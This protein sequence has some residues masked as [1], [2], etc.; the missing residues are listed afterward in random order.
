MFSALI[1]PSLA[2]VDCCSKTVQEMTLNVFSRRCSCSCLLSRWAASPPKLC[3]VDQMLDPPPLLPP[4]FPPPHAQSRW[5]IQWM[6]PWWQNRFWCSLSPLPPCSAFQPGLVWWQN[7]FCDHHVGLDHISG[8]K[9]QTGKRF[10]IYLR[11]HHQTQNNMDL[12][13]DS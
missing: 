12:K 9:K 5:W 3:F 13:V 10:F 7:L 8:G 11:K 6:N 2:C 1:D 4:I